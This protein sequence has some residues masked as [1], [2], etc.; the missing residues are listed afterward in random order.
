M[1]KTTVFLALSLL[2][3]AL[4]AQHAPVISP[5]SAQAHSLALHQPHP[6]KR[7]PFAMQAFDEQM[8]PFYH[9]VASGDPLP[10][11]VI[12]WTRVTPE[13]DGPVQVAWQMATDPELTQVVASGTVE[14][15]ADR[16]Y[17]VKVDVTDLTPGTTY[18]YH[19]E[20]LGAVS[21]TGRTKTAPAD[22]DHLRF[23]VVSCSNYQ[24]GYFSGYGRIA[25]RNDLDAVVH[26]GDYIYEYPDKTEA[27]GAGYG[28]DSVAADRPL[29]PAY[30]IVELIDYRT[31]YSLYRLDPDLIRAH[32]QHP[33]ITVWDDHES[34]NDSWMGGAENHN[35]D[36]VYTEG[37][38]EGNWNARLG[39]A[40]QAYFE[41]L[42]IRD[43]ADQKLY[44]TLHY[45][46]LLDLIMLDTRI[47]GRE[48]Q[49]T[50]VL[51]PALYDESRTLLGASQKAWL[52][53]ELETSEATWKVLGSQVMFAPF[54]V[55]W[56]AS[57]G[58]T[59]V[60]TESIFLD[61]WDGYP[62]ERKQL[63]TYLDTN[64][65]DN[66]VVISGDLHASFAFDLAY[67]PSRLTDSASVL[68]ASEVTYDPATGEG[69]FAVEFLTPSINSAN[70][71]ENVG[72]GQ[73][74]LL[75]AFIN[76]QLPPFA[77]IPEMYQNI[78]PN[79]H[80]KWVDLD[81]H[82]YFL[83][84]VTPEA[85]QANFYY[86]DTILAPNSGER[87][88]AGMRT[89]NGQNHLT[90]AP[91][92]PEKE[93]QDTPAPGGPVTA[94]NPQETSMVLLG[95]YP[96]PLQKQFVVQLALNARRHVAIDLIDLQ[97]R[98]VAEIHRAEQ[99]PGS[100]RMVFDLPASLRSGVYLC[101]LQTDGQTFTQRL[102]V[103]R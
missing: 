85:A 45:G 11:A 29:E 36:H 61:I 54:N 21:L 67:Q 16:D 25:D 60:Q 2:A 84:D 94:L 44:R 73:S 48:Q 71:D 22:P 31:R 9:G 92:S 13:T 69:S 62:A 14:T 50:N 51:T 70:F 77:P 78:N 8:K 80:M 99:A 97:G 58:A 98:Q 83:L 87:F 24:A 46:D 72:K 42:P 76:Q 93:M 27:P 15:H 28:N 23:V 10:D 102:V 26:L 6:N 100:Y 79:P 89:E 96:N 30:E 47:E 63:L 57:G 32:Q 34:A 64:E 37:K 41:W 5:T 59:P 86:L 88:V 53:N 52:L 74:D 49:E 65:V 7:S 101:R 55:A 75:E 3:G 82:G 1:A 103:Q 81:R 66:V 12:L 19:F 20:A 35:P 68:P 33:F 17:T 40:R 95:V 91:E 39:N 43:R 38:T 56:A 90:S 4:H 18:Y